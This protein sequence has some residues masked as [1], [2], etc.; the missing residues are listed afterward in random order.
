M[1][2]GI[3]FEIPNEYG[4]ALKRML[5]PLPIAA[6]NWYVGGEECYRLVDKELEPL[7][8]REYDGMDGSKLQQIIEYPKV[9]LIFLTLQ[10]FPVHSEVI[11]IRTYEEF[12]DS[13]CRFLLLI[14]DSVY[15]AMYG[16]D[17][18]MLAALYHNAMN[19]GYENVQYITDDNDCRT[20]LSVW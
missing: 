14:I 20:K 18:T 9:Y 5:A 6:Y 11:A 10:A 19:H 1:N 15:V 16:K 8:A 2:R 17:D 12:L 4:S 7:F 13:D 3:S